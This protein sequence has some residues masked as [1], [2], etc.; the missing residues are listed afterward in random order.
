M[1]YFFESGSIIVFLLGLAVGSFLNVIVDRTED[2]EDPIKGRS[3]CDNCKKKLSALDL[4]PLLSFL[5][6]KG[7]CRYCR[8]K[9]SLYYPVIEL[10]T[11]IL[12]VI[13][14]FWIFGRF[15]LGSADIMQTISLVIL[16]IIISALVVIFFT[17]M[18]Y[19]LIPFKAV[20][21]G[22]LAVIAWNMFFST[23]DFTIINYL[24][25]AF[26]SFVAFLLLFLVTRGKGIGFGD[27][28]YVFLMGLLLGY[29][30]IIL[31]FYIAFI[32][33]AL[34]SLILIGAKK[35][36]LKGSTIPFGPFLV[37][38]TIV[39]LFWGESLVGKILTY[40]LG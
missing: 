13:S 39:C 38:G 37:L 31:G 36:K 26:G 14:F 10:T 24:L 32:S 15:T 17:D 20:L 34:I 1:T 25:S 3:H 4:V 40:L 8:K 33:G 6:L 12:F 16:L 35:K 9:L 18:K 27:V 11:A 19:G 29:P 21:I 5:F 7:K 30:N 2:G 22:I 28:V 23:T